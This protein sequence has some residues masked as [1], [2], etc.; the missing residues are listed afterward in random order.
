MCG[1]SE[2]TLGLGGTHSLLG[3]VCRLG[4]CISAPRAAVGKSVLPLTAPTS[5][6]ASG[7]A[8]RESCRNDARLAC[9][10]GSSQGEL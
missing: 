3:A 5:P 2:C 4:S 9:C 7:P 1:G 6:G 8:C 10:L